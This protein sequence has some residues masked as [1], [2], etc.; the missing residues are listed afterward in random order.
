M[1]K[2]VVVGSGFGGL[3]SAAFL[4]KAGYAVTVY[5]KNRTP[6]GR[7]R[8]FR[9]KGY[10]FDMGPSWYTMPDIMERFF[11]LLG[12]KSKDYYSLKRLDPSYR[13]MFDK[14]DIVDIS[15]S[16]QKNY[17]LFNR[18]EKGGGEKLKRYLAQAKYQY[19]VAM[20]SYVIKPYR[21]V[22]DMFDIRMA[23]E[24][25]KLHL[26]D[27]MDTFVK[28]YFE[29]DRLRK[30]LQYTLVFLGG[31]PKNTPAMY[32]LMSH[33]DFHMGV[34]YPKGG[35]GSVVTAVETI[36]KEFGAKFVYGSEVEKIITE[37]GRATGV[38]VRGKQI[39]ADI[40]VM[41]ADYAHAELDLLTEKDR[42]YKEAYW[43]KRVLAPSA[44]LMY[45]GINRRIPALKHHTLL[46]AH[47]W[48]K[49][50]D[51][52]FDNP[53]WPENPSVYI[54]CPSKTDTSVAPDGK[55]NLVVLV[56][57]ASGLPDTPVIRSMYSEKILKQLEDILQISIR[58]HVEFKQIYSIRDFELDY[59]AYRGTGLGLS[60]TLFQTAI[61]RPS[62]RSKKVRNLFFVGQY[63]HPG[64]GIP[65][66]L[67]SAE[68]AVNEI[69]KEYEIS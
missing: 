39:Q 31:S 69:K 8:V 45:L 5:E 22:F 46:F 38:L 29:N 48:V 30:I 63:T 59:N 65:I 41:N 50:F 47:D 61:F 3:A 49:H 56:P 13:V 53:S 43:K 51:A 68:I 20:S 24:A 1:K 62:Y 2:V 55:E 16:L 10:Q 42:S 60:H 11:G 54:C 40:V 58:D 21:S 4:A 32:A 34:W 26:L 52:I 35:I 19:D 15:A 7:A 14:N 64:I 27:N 17:A 18:L 37:N 12:K 57:V 36:A 9:K 6:G 66:Q 44:F 25:S 28:R 23:K 67:I 33:V